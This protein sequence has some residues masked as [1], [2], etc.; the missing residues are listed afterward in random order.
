MTA[1]LALAVAGSMAAT[2]PPQA[3]W[4]TPPGCGPRSA[5]SGSPA[6]PSAAGSGS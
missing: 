1:A 5:R 3:P 6:T 2:T 4:P